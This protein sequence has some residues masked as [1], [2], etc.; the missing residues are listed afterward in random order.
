MTDQSAPRPATKEG[1]SSSQVLAPA[2]RAL[3]ATT[4]GT[5]ITSQSHMTCSDGRVTLLVPIVGLQNGV[6]G[7][8]T[9]SRLLKA[10]VRSIS[11]TAKWTDPIRVEPPGGQHV[12]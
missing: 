5:S 10:K 8:S 9:P 12:G 4:A 2:A 11:E 1:R 6:S 3:L 7:M